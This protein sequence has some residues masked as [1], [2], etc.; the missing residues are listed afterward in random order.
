[1]FKADVNSREL[2]IAFFTG[3]IMGVLTYLIIRHI[4][5]YV[6]I[7]VDGSLARAGI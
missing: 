4:E 6:R 2:I 3:A 1:M 5:M 7:K